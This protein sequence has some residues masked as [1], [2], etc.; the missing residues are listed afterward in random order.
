MIW[1][2]VFGAFLGT[3]AQAQT[4][5]APKIVPGDTW[6]VQH[7]VERGSNWQQTRLDI[8]IERVTPDS[9]AVSDK[10]TGSTLPP[11]EALVGADW[12]R[13][14][15]VNGHQTV[16]NRPLSFPL[17]VGKSW[18]VDYSENHPNRQHS[19]EHFHTPYKVTGWEDITVPAGTFH[20]IKIE[21]E[22]EW[23][24]TTAPAI[25]A[26]SGSRVDAQ[27]ATTVMQTGRTTP[28]TASGRTYKALWYVPEVKRWVKSVEEYYTP[29]GVRNERFTEELLSYKTAN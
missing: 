18:L 15:S 17:S 5:A 10:T 19:N 11:I 3:A 28:T 24:A 2:A 12:S 6:T 14:R 27:G 21:A 23:S 9:I 26:V 29:G 22:G 7:T 4:V 8:T 25:A 16:I 1:L 20:A 13:M